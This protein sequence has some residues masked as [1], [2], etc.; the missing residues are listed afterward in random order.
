MKKILLTLAAVA[1]VAS[2]APAKSAKRGVCAKGSRAAE[3][4]LLEKGNSWYYN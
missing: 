3:F 4:E 2:A 1:L